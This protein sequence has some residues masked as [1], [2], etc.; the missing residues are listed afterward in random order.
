MTNCC[1]CSNRPTRQFYDIKEMLSIALNTESPNKIV[2]YDNTKKVS[3]NNL[4]IGMQ[5]SKRYYYAFNENIQNLGN[6]NLMACSPSS[7]GSGGSQEVI[8]SI[9]IISNNAFSVDF[10]AGADLSKKFNFYNYYESYITDNF[11]TLPNLA[12]VKPTDNFDYYMGSSSITPLE[13]FNNLSSTN[14][15]KNVGVIRALQPNSAP[16]ASK[17]HIFT[18]EYEHIDGE[19]FTF[20]TQNIDFL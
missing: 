18:I 11:E 20:V 10:P 13:T 6:S 19:K 15:T 8:K 5:V 1:G 2:P 9:K 4:L 12:M 17:S 14:S 16:T 3:Y 7:E